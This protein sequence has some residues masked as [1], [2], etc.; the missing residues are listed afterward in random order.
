MRYVFDSSPLI[1]LFRHYYPAR[2][3]TLWQNFQKL[4]D[5]DRFVSVREVR[6]ELEG[7]EDALS[8][9]VKSEGGLF[10]TP[11]PEELAFV[12][13]IFQVKHFQGMIRKKER[14]SGRPV[15]DPFV[16][17]KAK[18]SDSCVVT[19]EIWR[20]N[21]AKIPNVCEYFQIPCKNFEEFMEQENWKF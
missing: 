5:D 17:A 2:F 13:Q 20:E 3:P 14:L 12:A 8:G 9:W 6:R 7:S 16:I 10:T 11:S 21:G 4:I 1:N 19:S 18:V 15:A